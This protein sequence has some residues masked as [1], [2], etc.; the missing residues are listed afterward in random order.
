MEQEF[1]YNGN[2]IP[3][4]VERSNSDSGEHFK[5]TV[6]G[7]SYDFAASRI[8][9]NE[10]VLNIGGS[11]RRIFVAAI[12][13]KIVVH[14]DGHVLEFEKVSADRKTF[15]KDALE[16]GAK[17]QVST[18][19]PG[20]IVKILVAEGDKIKARQPLVIVE[21]MKMENEIKS[22][23]DGTVKSIHFSPGD[24]VGTG[25]AII[26]IEPEG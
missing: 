8:S 7:V 25:Q 3:V 21:S 4:S 26:K 12:G 20:K 22:P 10:L 13:E 15:S 5:A 23:T 17:D 14:N 19:M 6:E 11:I 24:L 16:F 9:P 18:P 1:L 2:V